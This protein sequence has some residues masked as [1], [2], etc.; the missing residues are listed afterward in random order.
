MFEIAN[1]AVI[2]GNQ[3]SEMIGT[4]SPMPD[5]FWVTIGHPNERG[6]LVDHDSWKAFINLVKTI[7]SYVE[8]NYG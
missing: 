5:G 2:I 8:K 3:D 4:V 7:D 1:G 6:V